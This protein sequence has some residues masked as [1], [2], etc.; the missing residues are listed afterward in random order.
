MRFSGESSIMRWREGSNLVTLVCGIADEAP[1]AMLLRAL[2][3]RRAN[4]LLVD[5]RL[6]ADQVRLR[7]QLTDKGITG[8]LQVGD[9]IL[10]VRDIHSVFHRFMNPEDVPGCDN[11]PLA[12]RKTR[13]ILHSLMSLFD[14]LPARVVNRRRPMMSNNSKP[15]QALL[16]RQAGFAIPETLVTNDQRS[17]LQ[18]TSSKGPLVYK[19]MSSVRSIVAGFDDERVDRIESLRLLPTQFQRRIMGFNVRVHVIGRRLFATKIL[20]SAVDYRYAAQEGAGATFC[21][22]ELTDAL[23][24]KCLQLARILELTFAGI[25]LIVSPEKVYCLEVNPAPGYSYYQEA[26]GQPIS[27]A[28]GAYLAPK[29]GRKRRVQRGR[30]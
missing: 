10:D 18:F 5:Q 6:L 21:P 17:L 26:T 22:Y 15:Y 2:R 14:L 1:V 11:S 13:S 4:F 30:A 24:N 20:S 23:R 7:W 19:S 25:D 3:K 27:D 8:H 9:E 28:L 16:I 29:E 12:V